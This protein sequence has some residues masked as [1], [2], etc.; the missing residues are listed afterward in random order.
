MAKQATIY[1]VAARAGVSISTVSNA[2]NRPG[3]VNAATRD[4]VLRVAD[5]LGFVPKSAAVSQARQG[6][7]CI[8]VLAPFTSYASYYTRL[9]GLLG[10]LRES[11]Y[12]VR[13]VDI[14][15]AATSS[16][17]TL[18]A[19]AI[20]GQWDGII[21]MGEGIDAPVERRLFEREVQTVV[22]D[23]TSDVF[24]TI[25]TDDRRGGAMAAAHLYGL[26][27]RRIGYLT[28]RQA[29][30]YQSQ[31]RI[32][33]AGFRDELASVGAAE[34]ILAFSGST[35]PLARE[36]AAQLLTGPNRPTAVMAHFDD[37][38]FGVM[39]A[40]RDLGLRV[41]QDLSIMGYDDGPAA[42]AVGLTTIRQPF[43]ETGAAAARV[44]RSQLSSPGP[45][46]VT[47]MDCTLTVRTSTAA[48]ATDSGQRHPASA[49]SSRPTAPRG[50]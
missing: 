44:L 5:E 16:S 41:P 13:V 45:R 38:A 33:L 21:V 18:A 25:T 47:V 15:S 6:A 43:A 10:E 30:E 12:E 17:P 8:A 23:A 27:H 39:L 48:P 46:T 36:A 3:R 40:A 35:I 31:G 49:P 37:L 32:R 34:P 2:L 4:K 29:T 26:G 11:G 24:S 9:S 22:V 19:S 28:E 50:R 14:E 20:R 7:G 42:E 1:D